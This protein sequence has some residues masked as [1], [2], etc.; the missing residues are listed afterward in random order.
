MFINTYI[1]VSSA[2]YCEH[3][4]CSES[5]V[6]QQNR[7]F[8]SREKPDSLRGSTSAAANC[9]YFALMSLDPRLVFSFVHSFILFLISPP[10]PT[11]TGTPN[12]VG[13]YFYCCHCCCYYCYN[14]YLFTSAASSVIVVIADFLLLLLFVFVFVKWNKYLLRMCASIWKDWLLAPFGA[15]FMC[16]AYTHT[17]TS[18]PKGINKHM[19]AHTHISTCC[20]YVYF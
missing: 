16:F 9:I 15:I 6:C 14:N 10:P 17:H 4:V 5:C 18:T 20:I 19:Y 11:S 7:F 3:I 8:C 13:W 2:A 12:F 1:L